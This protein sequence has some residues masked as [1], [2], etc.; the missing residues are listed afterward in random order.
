MVRY[1]AL[2]RSFY[3]RLALPCVLLV[4]LG[5]PSLVPVLG[6]IRSLQA[7]LLVW[8]CST[9]CFFILPPQ[10]LV[11]ITPL[12]LVVLVLVLLH[13]VTLRIPNA[14]LPCRFSCHLAL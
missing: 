7:G 3:L 14:L 1:K 8:G 5:L 12:A 10:S 4:P 9:F 11:P 2:S 6:A 13:F